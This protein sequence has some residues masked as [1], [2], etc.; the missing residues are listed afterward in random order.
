MPTLILG[1]RATVEVVSVSVEGKTIAIVHL[2]VR[3]T[4]G[5]R[6]YE[7]EGDKR[8]LLMGYHLF[9]HFRETS[10]WKTPVPIVPDDQ[11]WGAAIE[12]GKTYEL[13]SGESLTVF[14]SRNYDGSEYALK[15]K[16][17]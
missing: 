7:V 11:S 14:R 1:R 15:I 5:T 8:D 6:V 4:N 3:A 10:E 13:R 9:A 2:R 16:I 17:E 12:V